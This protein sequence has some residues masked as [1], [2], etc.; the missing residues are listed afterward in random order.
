[1]FFRDDKLPAEQVKY[2][3][4]RLTAHPALAALPEIP[5]TPHASCAP[6]PLRQLTAKVRID[7]DGCLHLH[8]RL[9]G[10][11]SEIRWPPRR[12][13]ENLATPTDGLWQHTCCEA[14][15]AEADSTAYRE[16]N[17]SPSGEWANYRFVD[18]R[19]RDDGFVPPAAP[20]IDFVRQATDCILRVRIPADSLPAERVLEIG[21][22]AV[23]ETVAGDKSYWALAHTSAQPDFH[24]NASFTLLLNSDPT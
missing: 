9:A 7:A 21:L 4:L 19:K 3:L 6:T 15:I 12:P 2:G 23:I 14:F 20:S 11:V 16:F 1:M 18:Y 10:I 13:P 5:L 24:L 8:Y 17:F 22:S